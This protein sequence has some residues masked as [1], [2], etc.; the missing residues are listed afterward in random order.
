MMEGKWKFIRGK[1]EKIVLETLPEARN[2]IL[3]HESVKHLRVDN[4]RN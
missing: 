1:R 4:R 3:N 2:E